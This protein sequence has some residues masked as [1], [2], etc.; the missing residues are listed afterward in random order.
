MGKGNGTYKIGP[1]TALLHFDDQGGQPG[2]HV[3]LISYTMKEQFTITAKTL[4]FTTTVVTDSAS[5]A[6]P[7]KC[8][9]AADGTLSPDDKVVWSTKVHGYRTDGTLDCNGSLCGTFG[10][11]PSG[12][13]EVHIG[14]GPVTF[15]PFVFAADGKTFTMNEVFVSKTDM[16]KQ[17]AHLSLSGRELRRTCAPTPAP[18]ACR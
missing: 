3:R 18:V 11:P 15:L 10:A 7:D 8:G 5:R 12:K 6:T 9:V 13:S 1:G 16:P 2:G 14:P 4:G 17:T